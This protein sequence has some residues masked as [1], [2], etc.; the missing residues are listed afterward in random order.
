MNEKSLNIIRFSDA[1]EIVNKYKSNFIGGTY[2]IISF[3]LKQLSSQTWITDLQNNTGSNITSLFNDIIVLFGNTIPYSCEKFT[4][5]SFD[6]LLSA[7]S[8]EFQLDSIIKQTIGKT[9]TQILTYFNLYRVTLINWSLNVTQTTAMTNLISQ[10]ATSKL[11]RQIAN[12][13]QF[14]QLQEESFNPLETGSTVTLNA[15]QP[16]NLNGVQ[17][18]SNFNFSNNATFNTN[19]N[20]RNFQEQESYTQFNLQQM[21]NLQK[22]NFNVI[23]PLIKKIGNLFWFFGDD[24]KGNGYLGFNLW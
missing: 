9:L 20:A 4:I 17:S 3:Y 13:S 21:N 15:V 24:F 2:D 1:I 14:N 12:N 18:S 5:Q 7:C 6:T 11:Q 10:N 8:S 22:H 23:T 16:A 19:S